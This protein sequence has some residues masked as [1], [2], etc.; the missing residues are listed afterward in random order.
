MTPLRMR[1][2]ARASATKL[3]TKD[4]P[5]LWGSPVGGQRRAVR[6]HRTTQHNTA[7]RRTAPHYTTPDQA[8]P[9][10]TTP[11]DTTADCGARR[12]ARNEEFLM[13]ASTEPVTEAGRRRRGHPRRL[14]SSDGSDCRQCFIWPS[15]HALQPH[16]T[17]HHTTPHNA[18]A[19]ESGRHS[20]GGAAAGACGW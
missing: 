14:P 8:R 11:Y 18:T 17:A 15:S 9:E 4:D 16:N 1:L 10:Q 5:S 7:P 13:A 6:P 3:G 12:P 2:A 19:G 20:V